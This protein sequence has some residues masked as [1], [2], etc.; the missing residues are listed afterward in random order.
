MSKLQIKYDEQDYRSLTAEK[1]VIGCFINNPALVSE[2]KVVKEDFC[3]S[4]A[5]GV[6]TAVERLAKDGNQFIDSDMIE[7]CLKKYYPSDYRIYQKSQGINFV[8]LAVTKC[9][10]M[11]FEANYNEL[12]KWTMLRS[13]MNQGIDIRDIYDPD[14]WDDEDSRKKNEAFKDMTLDEIYDKVQT[15]LKAVDTV[16]TSNIVLFDPLKEEVP[17]EVYLI[18]GLILD[19]TVNAIIAGSKVGKSYFLEEMLFCVENRIPWQ[20]REC[21]QAHCLLVDYE[22]TKAKVQKRC[23]KLMEKYQTI[24]PDR[25]LKMFDICLMVDN[26]QKQSVDSILRAIKQY[27]EKN[28]ETKLIGLDPFYRFFDGDNENDN[29]Q[30]G[31]CIGKIAGYKQYGL[32]F[33]Y[34]HHASKIGTKE[35][36]P[37]LACAGA[38]AHSRIVDQAFGLM[39]KN[40]DDIY[41]GVK[42]TN[43]G[44][45]DNGGF[46]LSRDEWGFFTIDVEEEEEI[47]NPMNEKVANL[48]KKYLSEK[49]QAKGRATIKTMLRAV[50]EANGLDY[51]TYDSFGLQIV[52]QDG[53]GFNNW[54]V[55]LRDNFG[56][57]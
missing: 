11:N 44:R 4:V 5:K 36:D 54:T 26:W 32:S 50:P 23:L 15:R 57:C 14:D 1:E 20:R 21:T 22:L 25:E 30:V 37:F 19:G 42:V 31:D 33:I 48:I 17:P 46:S 38:S 24:Y 43:K 34:S 49:K 39:P 6:Y 27:K 56:G 55:Q 53:Q 40:S 8:G 45:E 18:D 41:Q 16:S 47:I 35:K 10:P 28:P 13:F 51:R 12:K 29:V 52:K 7:D 2:Y 9:H 3:N